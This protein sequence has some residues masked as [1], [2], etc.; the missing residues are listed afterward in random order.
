MKK[1]FY[2][3]SNDVQPVEPIEE[4]VIAQLIIEAMEAGMTQASALGGVINACHCTIGEYNTVW[5]KVVAESAALASV[6][7]EGCTDADECEARLAEVAQFADIKVWYSK[8][9]AACGSPVIE[10]P[11]PVED[12]E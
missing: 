12:D 7:F 2:P 9:F 8:Y 5:K 4:K 10:S 1:Y 3:A 6:S 11:E